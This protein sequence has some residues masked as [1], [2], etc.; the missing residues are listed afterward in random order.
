[1]FLFLAPHVLAVDGFLGDWFARSD[2]AKADQPHWITPLVTVTPRLEQEFRTD[3]RVGFNPHEPDVVNYGNAKGLE[4]IP[5]EN[6]E[7]VFNVPPY[8][9]H[10]SPAV[11]DGFGDISFLGKYRLWSRNEKNG[12]YILTVFL[13]ATAPTGSYNNGSV[14]GVITPT[15]AGGKGWGKFDIQSTLGAGLPLSHEDV[16]GHA[17][18]SNTAFQYNLLAKLWPEVEVN[19]TYWTGGRLDGNKQVYLTAG[20]ILG[21]FKIRG[22]LLMAFGAGY[23]IALTNYHADNHAAVFTVRFPF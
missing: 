21:R 19:A 23:Q 18:A 20:L 4:L 17:I 11:H 3:F 5:Q 7:L 14:A 10:N 15:I 6:V 1:M 9:Q 22:R 8:L 16:L 13:A 12:N 2:K